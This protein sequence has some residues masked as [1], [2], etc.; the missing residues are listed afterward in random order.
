MKNRALTGGQTAGVLL[1]LLLLAVSGYGLYLVVERLWHQRAVRAAIPKYLEGLRAQREEL[2]RAIERYHAQFGF[3]P[4][5]RSTNA[6]RALVNPLYYELAG[7]RWHPD[8]GTFGLPTTKD[9]VKPEMMVKRFGMAAFS[10]ALVSPAWPTNFIEG[11]GLTGREEGE[12]VLVSSTTPDGVD[13]GLSDDFVTT[14]WRYAANPAEHNEG[15]FDI[16][17]ELTVLDQ[18]F[19]IGNWEGVR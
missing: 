7:T 11:G 15:R 10:N 1:A 3:Y 2:S 9:P 8:L 6:E 17:L 12:V 19:T 5:D 4:Q 16:W 13:E 14:A 18:H